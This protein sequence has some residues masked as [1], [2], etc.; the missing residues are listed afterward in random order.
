MKLILSVVFALFVA[1]LQVNAQAEP[2]HYKTEHQKVIFEPTM[3][4]ESLEVLKKDLSNHAITLHYDDL[5]FSPAGELQGISF[6]V[7]D[8]SGRKYE[9]AT[10]DLAGGGFFGFEFGFEDGKSTV[11]TVGTIESKP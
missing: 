7:K 11:F 3:N 4:K 5:T 10:N 9:A 8:S 2:R 6:N 1:A